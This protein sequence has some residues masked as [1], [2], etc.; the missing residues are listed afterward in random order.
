MEEN[1]QNNHPDQKPPKKPLNYFLLLE[2]GIEFAVMIALPLIAF[3]L[4]G[5][6]LDRKLNTHFIVIIGILS[7]IALSSY[8]ISRKIKEVL[9]LIK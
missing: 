6:W 2:L 9:N 1:L 7:A 4:A 3:I 8:I 5:Q